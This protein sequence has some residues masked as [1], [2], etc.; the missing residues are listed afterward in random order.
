MDQDALQWQEFTK[1]SEKA[2]DYLYEKF[3]PVLYDYALRFTKEEALVKDCIQELY[4]ELWEKRSNLHEVLSVKSYLY[5]SL[6]RKIVKQLAS[7]NKFVNTL[8]GNGFSIVLSHESVMTQKELMEETRHKLN[9]LFTTLTARQKEAIY[10]KFYDNLSYQEIATI[11]SFGDSRYA[12][13]LIYRAL[14]ELRVAMH[15]TQM[16]IT[17]PLALSLLLPLLTFA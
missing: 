13:Q 7:R 16:E 6:R 17:L 8:P 12:R 5:V 2:F 14:D 3:F 15:T 10:L 11:M 9:R 1:G 4:I